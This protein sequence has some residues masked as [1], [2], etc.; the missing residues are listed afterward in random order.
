MDKSILEKIIMNEQNYFHR[1]KNNIDKWDENTLYL[2]R[3]NQPSDYF[4]LLLS[5]SYLIEA[6]ADK[7]ELLAK[8]YD[9]YGEK[10]LLGERNYQFHLSISKI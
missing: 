9:H 2:Y 6:G 5:G 7:I 1:Y 10:A 3:Y 8:Q 4:V